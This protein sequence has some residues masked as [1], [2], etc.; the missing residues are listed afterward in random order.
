MPKLPG[1]EAL[2][3]QPSGRS[4]RAIASY[5][6]TSIGRGVATLGQGLRSLAADAGSI[7]KERQAEATQ[8]ERFETQRRFL[9]FTA[10]QDD[11]LE[12]AGQAAEPG[13]FG[14]RETTA[15][16]YQEAAKEF[17]S[18]VPAAL[19]G[20]YDARL[21]QA[22]DALSGRALTF[23]REAR[24]GYYSDK[25]SDGLTL[26]ENKLYANP[27]AL[28]E[29]LFE[30]NQFIDSVP[31]EDISPIAKEEMRRAWKTKAQL[32]SLNGMKPEERLDA[33]GVAP[34][35]A[36]PL[37]ADVQSRASIAR[38]HFVK[39][40]YTP[41]QAAG[42]V[43]NLVQESG[44]RP[45][46]AVG[47][48]GTAFG[49]AQWRGERLNRLKRYAAA[50]GKNWEDLGT[51]LDFVDVELKNHETGAYEA[52]KNAKTIEEA[53]AAFIGYE[54]PRGWTTANPQGGHG[55]SN[56]LAAAQRTAGVEVNVPAGQPDPKFAEVPWQTQ[57]K[58][59][60]EAQT[61]Q[62]QKDADERVAAQFAIETAAT[63]APV[64]MA[65][66][67]EYTGVMPTQDQFVAAYGDKAG[68]KWAE[69]Q[70]SVETGRVVHQMQTMTDEQIK[71]VVKAAEP[72]ATGE[73][74]A[75]Q[76]E[77]FEVVSKAADSALK[78]REA[79]PASYVRKVFPAVEQAWAGV[80]NGGYPAA[81][82]ASVAAQQQLGI[83]DIKPLPKSAADLVVSGFK[84]VNSGEDQRIAAVSSA[85]MATPDAAQRRAIFEQLV[86]AGLPPITEGAVEALARG[87]QGAADRLFQAAMV[88][89]EKLPGKA[90]EKPANIKQAI[91]DSLMAEGEV[92]DLYYGLSSGV[93]EN[94]TRAERDSQLLTNAVTIRLRNG[95]DLDTAVKGAAKDLFGDVQVVDGGGRVN[96]QILL[97][98]SEDADAVVD[99]L[100]ALE[101]ELRKAVSVEVPA[102]IPAKDGS[103]A[104]V[105][106]ATSAY[107]DNVLAEGFWRNSGDGFVFIDPF[108][109]KAI[110]GPDGTPIIFK[111]APPKPG[112]PAKSPFSPRAVDENAERQKAFQ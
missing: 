112:A 108:V 85:L 53:T 1:I 3:S 106:A 59:I 63:N 99:G 39:L 46:G 19:K 62:R 32:A 22:E 35:A 84:N 5:D 65:N 96:A 60:S 44:V 57:Q 26:I 66:T 43:G 90:P 87:D 45:S 75:L 73:G 64:A 21:F 9:E 54:R 17:F 10:R 2:G 56:R 80:A 25:V 89:V 95:E 8:Q 93:A 7:A 77:R 24:K 101:P 78:E 92:G 52:L 49:V 110:S 109:G 94:F 6:T 30:G 40:G 105:D 88:D 103:K 41:E 79:D 29:N 47:D 34:A 98:A 4:G 61:E 111:P 86:D 12:K 55:W 31:D 20:E 82:T 71:A 11:E 33:L 16:R 37:P 38:D 97:P 27:K 51:Q 81:I 74:A 18:T 70:S 69:F 72:T 76:Q 83:A 42:I 100:S 67:G 14:F 58:I 36:G 107:V 68:Q 104:I 28:E 13:A 50:N 91:Q 23:E 15:K 48:G 102:G